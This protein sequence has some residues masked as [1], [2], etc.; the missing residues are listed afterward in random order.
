MAAP[1]VQQLFANVTVGSAPNEEALKSLISGRKDAFEAAKKSFKNSEFCFSKGDP[2]D[3]V[4]D[5]EPETAE[6][7]DEEPTSKTL[8]KFEPD[9]DNGMKKM[10]YTERDCCVL[11]LQCRKLLSWM[12]HVSEER[13]KKL[14]EIKNEEELRNKQKYGLMS[15]Q[16][17]QEMLQSQSEDDEEDLISQIQELKRQL[18]V[19]IKTNHVLD[20]DLAK[21]DKRIALLVKN[22]TQLQDIKIGQV[23][24]GLKSRRRKAKT[25][26][27]HGDAF[28]ADPRKL[29][30][31]Q[32]LFYLLQTEPR[33]LARCL[34]LVGSEE[35]EN[36]LD[37][38]VL[39]LYGD[40]FSPREEFLILKLFQLAIKHEISVIK[41]VR[42]FLSAE[43]VVPKMIISY[44][45]RK[46]GLEYIKK[47]MEPTLNRTMKKE[48][49]LELNPLNI[50]QTRLN[51]IEIETG[52]K[53][54]LERNVPEEQAAND[55]DVKKILHQR[56]TDLQDTCQDFLDAIIS[57]MEDLPYGIRWICKTLIELCQKALPETSHEDMLRL[58]SYFVYYR[59]VNVA[60]VSPDAMSV[61]EQELPAVVRK[62]LV[63]ISKVL[64]NLFNFREFQES[65]GGRWLIPL[66]KFIT[67][68]RSTITNYLESLVKVDEP[69]DFLQV[70][71]Y[72]E[73]T[74]KTKPIILISL[75][76]I[77]STHNLLLK[78]LDAMSPDKD[79][80]MRKILN[81]LGTPPNPNDLP[82]EDD[83]EV[84]LTLTNRFKVD[85]EEESENMRLYTETKELIIPVLRV[86]PVQP[87][88]QKL[89][90]MDV[91]EAGINFANE[92]EN[93]HLSGQINKILENMGKLEK[94]DLISKD[95]NYESFV[96]DVALE[97]ANR[98]AIREAQRKEIAR[99][100]ATLEKLRSHQG[101]MNSQIEDHTGYLKDLLQNMG[102]AGKKKKKV[103]TTEFKPMGPIKFSYKDLQKKGVIVDSEVPKL[104]RK[105]T[106][107]MISCSEPG[108]FEVEAKIAGISVEKMA[109]QLDD[110]L[111][112]HY[113]NITRLELDQVTLDVNMTIFLLNKLFLK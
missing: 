103:K 25:G 95:D 93:K 33:Y 6:I 87:T 107:F 9:D 99:L 64:Q 34:Y 71:K 24:A 11:L 97:V 82:E 81:E 104:S 54:T 3:G 83:R 16:E 41:N 73:L 67:D 50:Y 49:N 100:T 42:D 35:M 63:V 79:D 94:E 4:D 61:T 52:E 57:S 7:L 14:W 98:H 43:T 40:A 86:V 59:F 68:N 46:Q 53:S 44:N 5:L 30:H 75:Q 58:T 76:E 18:A 8:I 72:V 108:V 55:P 17:I 21:L 66:N 74:Q 12:V 88:I 101:Y 78:H 56:L 62:N 102:H 10:L 13:D 90:L 23:T 36:F 2:D 27:G 70:N 77:Y 105:S 28:S 113:N 39:T 26:E 110:L 22:R 45:R 60:V 31:Y 32:D 109:L 92:T 106:N 20:R 80:P 48:L 96:H 111:E 91:L 47:M 19:Q 85:V 89:Y 51:E 38:V 69:E 112:R 15:V 29:E 65:E 84:Q 1:T 37:T